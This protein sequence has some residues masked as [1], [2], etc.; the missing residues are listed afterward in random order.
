MCFRR[1]SLRIV[2]VGCAAFVFAALAAPA[3][4]CEF[5]GV[6]RTGLPRKEAARIVGVVA[7]YPLSPTG[8]ILVAP[9]FFSASC[10]TALYPTGELGRLY[11]IGTTVV[12]LGEVRSTP[13][14]QAGSV[15]VAEMIRGGYVEAVPAVVP[16]TATGDLDFDHYDPNTGWHFREFEFDRAVV[17]LKHATVATRA[18]RLKNLSRYPPLTDLPSPRRA[19]RQLVAE[20]GVSPFERDHLLAA[21]DEVLRS[22]RRRRLRARIEPNIGG[23]SCERSSSLVSSQ[24]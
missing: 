20:S 14:T 16:R 17:A 10:Q 22:K 1:V 21:F 15:V 11:P 23:A 24:L 7:G 12:V 9:L 2:A 8:D 18:E 4:A 19:Y 5:V 13:D 6:A 3:E